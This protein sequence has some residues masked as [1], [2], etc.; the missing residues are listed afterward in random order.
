MNLGPRGE[1]IIKGFEGLRLTAYQV[2]PG[3]PWTIGWGHTHG[4][5]QSMTIDDVAA[6]VFFESDVA[7]I[8]PALSAL[9]IPTQAMFDALVSL[10]FNVGLSP[11]SGRTKIG[12]AIRQRLWFD[13]WAHMAQW[14]KV[15]KSDSLGLARRRA[16]EMKLFWEDGLN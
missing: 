2:G 3:D 7:R 14:R 16:A 13:V 15:G 4:V 11:L 12:W 10:C 8:V 1:Q 5:V 6:Q 9:D